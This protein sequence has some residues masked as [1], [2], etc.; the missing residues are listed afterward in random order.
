MKKMLVTGASGFLGRRI[1][2]FYTGTYEIFAPAH[3]ELDITEADGT[4]S[5][6]KKYQP[7]FAVHCAAMSDVGMCEEKPEQSW[8]INVTGSINIA[9]AAKEINGKC[10]LCSSDQVYFTGLE[11][12]ENAGVF[13]AH[14]EDEELC[15]GNL[16][17]REK[18]KAEQECLKVNP[19]CV[20]L[21]LSWMYDVKTE[22]QGE[23][24]DFFRTLLSQMA[25]AEIIKYPVYDRRGITDVNEVVKNLEKTFELP[26]GVY[27]FG[28]PNEKNTYETVRQ[29]FA[30]AGLDPGRLGK[31]EE[32]FCRNPRNLTMC[33]EKINKKGIYFLSTAEGIARNLTRALENLQIVSVSYA[34]ASS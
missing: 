28:S 11:S 1:V 34:S 30:Y 7:D 33:Q 32:A 31:N 14:R 19:D 17:G 6:F 13:Q 24:G 15:P 22:G 21:R 25:G 12:E 29:A 5:F 2:D 16:Y 23:H 4:V 3:G 9:K 10:I 20:L 18:L 27:N 26:G 8:N